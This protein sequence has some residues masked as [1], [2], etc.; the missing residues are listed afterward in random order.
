MD[1]HE[2]GGRVATVYFSAKRRM[3]SQLAHPGHHPGALLALCMREKCRKENT[4]FLVQAASSNT[5][6]TK[7]V[8]SPLRSAEGPCSM[9]VNEAGVLLQRGCR[10]GRDC[11]SLQ[12]SVGWLWGGGWQPLLPT[13][14]TRAASAVVGHREGGNEEKGEAAR[15]GGDQS[16]FCSP[17]CFSPLKLSFF[18]L[19]LLSVCFP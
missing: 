13:T 18:V 2:P 4:T 5:K 10:G 1:Y 19:F 16:F 6:S 17:L 15:G 12:E 7:Q 9:W 8:C 14:L 3:G 11:D